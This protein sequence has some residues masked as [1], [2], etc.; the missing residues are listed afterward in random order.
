MPSRKTPC[1]AAARTVAAFLVLGLSGCQGEEGVSQRTWRE[2]E[3][4]ETLAAVGQVPPSKSQSATAAA[5]TPAPDPDAEPAPNPQDG[6][7]AGTGRTQL[8]TIVGV[9]GDCLN[10]IMA[11]E[12]A[13]EC[14]GL[15]VNFIYENGRSSFFFYD[16]AEDTLVSFSGISG[17]DV[18]QGDSIIQPLDSITVT[19]TLDG[20]AKPESLRAIGACRYTNPFI[21]VG[22]MGCVAETEGG[23]WLGE[24]RSNG[25]PPEVEELG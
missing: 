25:E 15:L 8:K 14:R 7:E 16:D 19:R 24:F 13:P 4:A 11:D 1:A 6:D 17:D 2:Y 22:V 10:L 18:W 12:A 5:P 23:R 3:R 9:E 21:G 20:E